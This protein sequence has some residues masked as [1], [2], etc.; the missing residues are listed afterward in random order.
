[1]PARQKTDEHPSPLFSDGQL[2]ASGG[3]LMNLS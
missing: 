2:I 1:M 3:A